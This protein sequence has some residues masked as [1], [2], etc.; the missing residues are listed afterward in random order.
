[1]ARITTRTPST[2]KPLSI[3]L[4]DVPTSYTTLYEAPDFSVPDA[5]ERFEFRDPGDAARA[6]RPGEVFFL[7]PLSVRNKSSNDAWV[8]VRIL[9]EDGTPIEFGRLTIPAEDTGFVPLQG[10][11]ILKRDLGGTNGDRLQVR[12]ETADIFDVWTAAE[13]KLANEHSGVVEE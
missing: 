12:A 7:T 8:E 11:S 2:G 1:M 4:Q 5:S 13:E 6:I 9:L 10:R 3:N